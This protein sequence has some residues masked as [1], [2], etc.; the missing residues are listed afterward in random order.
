MIFLFRNAKDLKR[1]SP[2]V[3]LEDEGYLK[4][5]LARSEELATEVSEEDSIPNAL[6]R[7]RGQKKIEY[8]RLL[9]R[10]TAKQRFWRQKT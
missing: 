4:E 10:G 9:I 2:N 7:Q 8:R 6:D 5:L 3:E 1:T